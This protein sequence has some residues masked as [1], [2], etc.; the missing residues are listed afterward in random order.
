MV[1]LFRGAS[2][3]LLA[4]LI[5]SSCAKQGYPS[6]G[7]KDTAPPK[8]V[9]SK[10]DNETHHFD[11]QQFYIEFDEYVVLRDADNNVLVSPPL[12]QKAEYITKGKGIQVKIKDTLLENTTYLFQFKGAIADYTEGNVLQS[13]EYVF[14]T[15]EGMDTM[16][17]GGRV[18]SARDG[19]PWKEPLTVAAY[20][21]ERC[22]S[23]TFAL[24]ER[25]DFV[26]RSDDSGAF[27]FHYIPAGHYRL[28]AFSDNDRNLRVGDN[29]AVAFNGRLVAAADS[30][31]SNNIPLL[32][33]SAPDRRI[34]RILKSD[35]TSRGHITIVTLLPMQSPTITGEEVEWRLNQRRDTMTVWCLNDQCDSTVLVISDSSSQLQ[36]TLKMRHRAR[37]KMLLPGQQKKAS[38]L[39]PIKP[40]CD[41]AKAYYDDLRISFTNPIATT[42]EKLTAEVMLLKD[43]TTRQ[44]PVALDSGGLTAHIEASLTSGEKY[45]LQMR[46]SLFTDIYGHPYDSLSIELTPKD[47]GTLTIHI[48]NATGES[49]AVEVLDK[50]D[51]VVQCQT[52]VGVGGTLRFIHLPA[53]EYRLRAVV[54][55]NGDGQWTPGDYRQQRQPEE[56]IMFDKTLQLR[57]KWEMEEKWEIK[58]RKD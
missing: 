17:M 53:A 52:F 14:S 29:E 18:K 23:D 45:L 58:S 28:V 48:A 21:E 39:L 19:K 44:Y 33:V 12:K 3:T 2:L 56:C 8:A 35:F 42:A 11:R 1:K 27:A 49:L 30:L 55:N 10:P 32:Y 20:R 13:Y 57:E 31:D 24:T 6:G 9:A 15:G 40:L 43:S 51:T 50:R 38:N 47:Y 4:L 46:D 22:T 26:T 7:P 25:P 5:L 37:G 34:Q 36:D 54:D 41:G 16:M